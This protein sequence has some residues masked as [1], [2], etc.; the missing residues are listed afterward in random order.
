VICVHTPEV[1]LVDAKVYVELLPVSTSL[2]YGV[3]LFTPSIHKLFHQQ[4]SFATSIL[5]P[6]PMSV[7]YAHA[8][9][10]KS[11]FCIFNDG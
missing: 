4:V 9:I 10:V 8:V 6:G 1:R 3:A 2:I 5:S 7:G 11:H